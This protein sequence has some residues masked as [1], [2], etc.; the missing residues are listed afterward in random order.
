M[1]QVKNKR[2]R[3]KAIV[4]KL[5]GSK[6]TIGLNVNE[7]ALL[8]DLVVT[9]LEYGKFFGTTIFAYQGKALDRFVKKNILKVTPFG[10]GNIR[11]EVELTDIEQQEVQNAIENEGMAKGGSIFSDINWIIT[12]RSI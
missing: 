2:E 5:W 6:S 10:E 9:Y 7:R 8:E 1:T 12:G 4:E 11:A 3:A